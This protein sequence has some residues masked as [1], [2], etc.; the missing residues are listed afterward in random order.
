MKKLIIIL[1]L[2][3]ASTTWG[4]TAKFGALKKGTFET[5]ITRGGAA[6]S[7]NDTLA[8]GLPSGNQAFKF[9]TQGNAPVS[10]QLAGTTVIIDKLKTWGNKKRGFKMYAS[11]K[12]WGLVPVLIDIEPA[13]IAGELELNQ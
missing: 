4:Q 9:I 7:V 8:L 13:I 1:L 11:F 6:V 12:G 2:A 10:A 5:Y 3:A